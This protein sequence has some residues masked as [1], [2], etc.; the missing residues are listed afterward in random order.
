MDTS[1]SKLITKLL[2]ILL[3]TGFAIEL[4]LDGGVERRN[5]MT[6]RKENLLSTSYHKENMGNASFTLSGV[7][8]PKEC[9]DFIER[10]E[11]HGFEKAMVSSRHGAV[12]NLNVR[13]NDRVILD[14]P[15][16]AEQIWQRVKH[17]LPVIQQGREIR[18]LN[19]RFRFYRY[20][21]GQVFRWHHDGYFERDNGEQ[22]AL[23][24]LIYLNED[25]LG[26]ETNF[27]W[28]R[29]KAK[30]G[31]G[32]V[33]PHHLV[34]QGNAVLGDGVKYVIRTDVMY[35]QVGKFTDISKVRC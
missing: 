7:L 11:N 4:A 27:E 30:T 32:L 20:T 2:I 21:E 26:G 33:F 17:L 6:I 5:N 24:F 10:S 22:S 12:I 14:D 18:G 34:H 3:Y 1:Y 35:G 23:T 16:L 9:L 13:N 19:E 25:Y 29:V 28:T 15:E 31:M 8:T